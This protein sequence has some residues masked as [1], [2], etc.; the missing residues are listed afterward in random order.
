MGRIRTI[1]PSFWTD[2]DLSELPPETHM[3]AA[4]LLNYSDDEGYFNA[5]PKLVK[6]SCCPL[7]EDSTNVRRGLEQLQKMG[8]L[9][10]G[11]SRD[12][13]KSY[14]HILTFSDHQRVDRGKES[15]IKVLDIEWEQ[16]TNNRRTIDEQST[17]EGK[18]REGKG[19]TTAGKPAKGYSE[20][21]ERAWKAYPKRAGDN[22]KARAAK[23]WNARLREGCTPEEMLAGVERYAKWVR[24]Q[25]REGT[26]Y[27]KQAATFFGPDRGFE[28]LWNITKGY[29]PMDIAI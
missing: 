6:A 24:E 9:R 29:D 17:Q 22:P 15:K 12:D 14:G 28:S 3:L 10:L 13:G 20:D 5:N 16:S 2:E 18:G 19:S 21:F 7:R 1:K 4:S 27:V 25:D 8:Y 11:K 26:E 23:A